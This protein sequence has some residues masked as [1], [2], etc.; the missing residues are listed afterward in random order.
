LCRGTALGKGTQNNS[1]AV[2]VPKNTMAS[3]IL[4][5]KKYPR[6]LKAVIAA[7]GASTMYRVKGLNTYVN[8]IFK[9]LILY[10]FAKNSKNLFLLVIMGYCVSRKSI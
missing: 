4:K 7:K 9:F 2:K 10:K 3:I 5:W 1:A 6:R 8:V